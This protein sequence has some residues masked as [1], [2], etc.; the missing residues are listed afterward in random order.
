M[1]WKAIICLFLGHPCREVRRTI[2]LAKQDCVRCKGEFV[3]SDYPEHPRHVL[4][5]WDRDFK[6]IFDE[7]DKYI[8]PEEKK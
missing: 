4:L 2:G 5:R 7:H 1:N 6:Q 8:R 3:S